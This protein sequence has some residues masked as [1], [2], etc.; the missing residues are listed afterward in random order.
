MGI[1]DV[2][3]YV[4]RAFGV[5]IKPGTIRQW[6]ARRKI[7]TYGNR[8]ERY[9]LREVV[10]YATKRGIIRKRGSGNDGTGD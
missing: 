2:V 5:E 8:R 1:P 6:A 10:D 4:R 7:A 3:F 9:D